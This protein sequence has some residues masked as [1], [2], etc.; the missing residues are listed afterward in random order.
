MDAGLASLSLDGDLS[1]GGDDHG[2]VHSE[3]DGESE[4]GW[5]LSDLF[6][7]LNSLL[8]RDLFDLPVQ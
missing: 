4:D 6:P 1:H 5:D 7:W 2:H 3:G 8:E